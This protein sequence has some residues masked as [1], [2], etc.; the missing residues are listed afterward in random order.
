[1]HSLQ[2]LGSPKKNTIDAVLLGGE[3]AHDESMI[4]LLR[5]VLGE[6]Y[7]NGASVD[8]SLTRTFSPDLTFVGSRAAAR[9]ERGEKEHRRYLETGDPNYEP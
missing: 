1:L 9:A 6:V 2:R 4:A 3:R 5:Q 8:L 7:A